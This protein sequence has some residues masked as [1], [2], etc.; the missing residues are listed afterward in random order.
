MN[1]LSLSCTSF[2]LQL[3]QSR[4]IGL[5]D[6]PVLPLCTACFALHVQYYHD[7]YI[8][9]CPISY[10][11]YFI[12]VAVYMYFRILFSSPIYTGTG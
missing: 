9:V 1:I 2:L 5:L 7:S 6:P 11:F 3:N 12:P 4:Y 8:Y 10:L